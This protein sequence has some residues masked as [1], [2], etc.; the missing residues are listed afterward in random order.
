MEQHSDML[1]SFIVPTLD[2]PVELGC[3]LQSTFVQTRHDFEVLVLDQGNER[4]QD[5]ALMYPRVKYFHS[6]RKGLAVNR[7]LG[8]RQ[9]HGELLV[10]ADDDCVLPD[11]YVEK[12]SR[13][14]PQ[15][16]DR[17]LFGFGN[18]LNLEDGQ[19]FVPTFKPPRK[20]VSAWNCDTLCSVGLVFH[21]RSF[22]IAGLFDEEFGVGARYPA[23]EELELLLR[24]LSK[25]ISGI[26]LPDLV[27]LHPRRSREAALVERYE[28]YGFGQGAVA[29]KHLNNRLYFARYLYGLA[30]PLGGLTLALLRRNGLA[31]LYARTLRGKVRG[32]FDYGNR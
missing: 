19:P 4:V 1:V 18:V 14:L 24:L 26:Y 3:F 6:E 22:E 12:L 7:N 20:P 25:G 13:H 10:F 21:R 16:S 27:I 30:R 17:L 11:D 8:I 29:R 15:L 28:K 31:K 5:I 23:G 32:F 9:A 2:R